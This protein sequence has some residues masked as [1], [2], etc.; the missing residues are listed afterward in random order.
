MLRTRRWGRF[1]ANIMHF[2]KTITTLAACAALSGCNGLPGGAPSRVDPV[3]A[4]PGRVSIGLEEAIGARENPRV[5]AEYGGVYSDPEVEA[6]LATIVGRLVQASDDP[7]RRYRITVLNSPVAN[8]FALP[9]GYLYVTR[10]LLALANDESELAAVLSHEIA[11]V[12]A[13]HALERARV[14]ERA[15]LVEKVAT[16]VLSDPLVGKAAVHRSKLTLAR[17]T[18]TQEI[19]ADKLGIRIAG[20]AGF[21]PFAASRFIDKLQK[22]AAF[23]SAIGEQDEAAGF[24]TSHPEAPQRRTLAVQTARQFGAPGLGETRREDYLDALDGIIFGDDPAQGFVRGREFLHPRLSI[25]FSVPAGYR[26]ENTRSAV[27]AA[28]GR[29]RAMRF[30]GVTVGTASSPAAYLASGWVNGLQ[31]ETVKQTMVNGLQAATAS[32][33][34]GQWSFRIAV[35]QVGPSM[36]R[37]IFADRGDG[38]AIGAALQSTLASFRRLTPADT[39]RLRPLRIETVR[40]RNGDSVSRLAGR[41]RGTDRRIELFRILNGI[42]DGDAVTPGEYY[43]IV[44]D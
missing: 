27:L 6:V 3:A 28:A 21:D 34:A 41:I 35:V 5:I 9:G 32:A 23:R 11:H 8:A 33:K 30:D 31:P 25:G 18:Q 22:Y 43:K 40:A 7:T 14:V 1:A 16:D 12:L 24:L 19:E 17:F 13:N 15:G 2:R 36:Y 29:D 42:E 10:G 44:G 37:I 26:L 20:N 38:S 4:V 39:A